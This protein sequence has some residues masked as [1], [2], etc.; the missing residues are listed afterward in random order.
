MGSVEYVLVVGVYVDRAEAA[1]DLRD[2]TTRGGFDRP[3]AGAG[4]L[5]RHG[6]WDASLQQGRGGTLA[7]GIGTGAAVGIVVGVFFGAPLVAGAVGGVVGGFVGRRVGRR[8]TAGLVAAVADTLPVGGAGLVAVVESESLWA[9]RSAMTR[10]LRT[11][12]RVLDSG[13]LTTSARSLVR[14]NPTVLESL[15]AQR[16]PPEGQ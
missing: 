1:A 10:A 6:V 8:E 11:S 7:Y 12:G 9:V 2:L 4:I 3:I 16:R 14:G 5:V 15:D 13:S